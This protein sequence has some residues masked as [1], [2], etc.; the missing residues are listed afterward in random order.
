MELE[1]S[2]TLFKLNTVINEGYVKDEGK[3]IRISDGKEFSTLDE[4]Y[5]DYLLNEHDN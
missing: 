1:I 2:E 4:A 3:W 5:T